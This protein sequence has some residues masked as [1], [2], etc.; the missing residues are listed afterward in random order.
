MAYHLLYRQ[1]WIWFPP[2]AGEKALETLPLASWS[3]LGAPKKPS[4]WN[5]EGDKGL[6]QLCYEL[7]QAPYWHVVALLS[8][9]IIISQ[10][11]W[12][13]LKSSASGELNFL[14]IICA[15]SLLTTLTM[16]PGYSAQLQSLASNFSSQH[17]IPSSLTWFGL[18]LQ[19]WYTSLNSIWFINA[20]ESEVF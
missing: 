2:F 16:L 7:C 17:R 8:R 12:L 19:L 9:Y 11:H 15:R 3:Q 18:T 1:E 20:F 6:P 5:D 14:C 13:L 4:I 10:Y